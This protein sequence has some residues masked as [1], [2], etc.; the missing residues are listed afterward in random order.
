MRV[1]IGAALGSEAADAL[2]AYQ[3]DCRAQLSA[4]AEAGARWRQ[5]EQLHITLAFLGSV[6]SE[7]V[8]DIAAAVQKEAGA[9]LPGRFC[10][11]PAGFFPPRGRKRVFW[12]GIDDRKGTLSGCHGAV[13]SALLALGIETETRP[14]VPH[15]TLARLTSAEAAAEIAAAAS[16]LAPPQGSVRLD[17][18][19]MFQSI[20][21]PKFTEYRIL[22]E[23][24]LG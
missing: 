19:T 8:P 2:A 17:R 1:F 4:E 23:L 10:L 14:F 24:T 18:I 6:E 9:V 3:D 12:A 16:R 7:I 22:D 21:N 15:V 5:K 20:T 11:A 13:V